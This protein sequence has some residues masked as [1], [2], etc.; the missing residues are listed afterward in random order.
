MQLDFERDC[1]RAVARVVAKVIAVVAVFVAIAL[2]CGCD[3]LKKVNPTDR[4]HGM[5]LDAYSV[6]EYDRPVWLPDCEH[7]YKVYDRQ[8]GNAW[9]LLDMGKGSRTSTSSYVV[10]PINDTSNEKTE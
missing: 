1:R 2:L 7:A 8:T 3:Y 4:A 9:W 5:P 10:L 6:V